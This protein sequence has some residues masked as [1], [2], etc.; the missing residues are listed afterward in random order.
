MLSFPAC[1]K[2]GLDDKMGSFFYDIKYTIR[3]WKNRPEKE[4]SE[5]AP[6]RGKQRENKREFKL[7]KFL[8]RAPEIDTVYIE[9]TLA[10]TL[11]I[12]ESDWLYIEARDSV[13]VTEKGAAMIVVDKEKMTL[14]VLD[15]VSD[16]IMVCPIGCGRQYGNKQ[17][18]TDDRTPEGVFKVR[19]IE[20]SVDWVHKTRTGLSEYGV[21]GPHFIRLEYPP[22]YAIGIHG[23]NNPA[24]L[25]KRESEGCI[26]VSNSDIVALSKLAYPGMSVIILPSVKDMEEN[27]KFLLAY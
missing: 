22:R 18:L 1:D 4:K 14:A 7:P 23:T 3:A 11:S 17:E 13:V 27:V 2:L 9:R 16:T 8:K 6:E 20:N 25:S 19:R 26:R 12:P 24:S 5:S 21:Y 15:F 10:D